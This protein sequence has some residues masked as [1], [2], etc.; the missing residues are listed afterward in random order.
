[1]ADKTKF[2]SLNKNTKILIFSAL[3]LLILGAVTAL[4]LLFPGNNKEAENETEETEEAVDTSL[5]FTDKIAKDIA[6]IKITNPDDTYTIEALDGNQTA[7]T[8]LFTVSEAKSAPVNTAQMDNTTKYI[9]SITAKQLIEENAQDMEKYGLKDTAA[10]AVVSFTDGTEVG[11]NIGIEAPTGS[12]TYI[13]RAGSNDVYIAS[14]YLV[15]Y[16]LK[17]RYAYVDTKVMVDYDSETQPVISRITV[18]KP[19]EEDV[20][21]EA[22]PPA[23][24]G[25]IAKTFNTHKFTSPFNIEIEQ[26]KGQ[27]LVYGLYGLTAL[28][29]VW[30]G[31]EEK[32]YSLSGLDNPS[33]EVEMQVG[34]KTYTLTLGLPVVAEN[35]NEDGVTERSLK[36]Y[37]GVFSEVPD[38]LYIFPPSALPW[39]Y[40]DYESIMSGLFM[41]PYIYSVSDVIVETNDADI[42]TLNFKIV[43]DEDEYKFY[44]DGKEIT[45]QSR[46]KT[47]YQFLIGAS[48]E[49]LY[50]EEATLPMIARYTYKYKD[51]ALKDDVVEFYE[52][53]DRKIIIY[54][55]GEPLFK[56]RALY[57]AR[58]MQN[59]EAFLNGGEL[60]VNW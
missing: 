21:I 37:Y 44:L 4:L 46:F 54:V 45:D 18:K 34:G 55:N 47:L 20:V 32:D 27:S 3:G 19:D 14:T 28:E 50:T 60:S 15:S 53:D 42:G 13:C 51:T 59:L 43:G 58:L 8:P 2:N 35:E 26:T 6:F 56:C 7:E 17:T 31:L 25:E 16:L 57:T 23:E 39:L 1:M 36:G 29:A 49:T 22:L 41:L 48:A 24:E 12:A 5:I 9:S 40:I 33:C 11:L 30:V 52:S 38:V 10:N